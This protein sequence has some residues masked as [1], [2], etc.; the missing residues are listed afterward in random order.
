MDTENVD[1]LRDTPIT[2]SLPR[3]DKTPGPIVNIFSR[4]VIHRVIASTISGFLIR[5]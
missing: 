2:Q 3:A 1:A 4:S 5:Q